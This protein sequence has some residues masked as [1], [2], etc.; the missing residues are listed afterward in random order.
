[1]SSLL[2]RQQNYKKRPTKIRALSAKMRSEKLES[3][4]NKQQILQPEFPYE[5]AEV[6]TA[7]TS[8]IT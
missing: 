7:Q 4:L 1:M 6:S 2:A 8:N 3:Q 5:S